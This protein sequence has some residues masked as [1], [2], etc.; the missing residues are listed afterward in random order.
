MA[1]P[2]SP[3][4]EDEK[5]KIADADWLLSDTP[6]AKPKAAPTG[7]SR[8]VADAD[9]SY[10]VLPGHD[11]PSDA[12]EPPPVPVPPVTPRK[13]KPKAEAREPVEAGPPASVDQVWS[14]GAEWGSSLF[15]L[16]FAAVA[17]GV[18]IYIALSA[19]QFMLAFL[20]AGL[21]GAALLAL[22]YPIF[23]TLERPVRITPEQAAK[24]YFAT[25]SHSLP[26]YQRMWLLLSSAGRV[27]PEFSSYGAFKGY[28]K[29]TLAKLQGG[30]ASQLNPLTFQ[31]EDF[32][33]EKSAGMTAINAKYTV[34]VYRGDPE[35]GNEVASYLIATSL[36]KGPDR[37]WYLNNGKLPN[38]QNRG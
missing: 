22:C 32:H 15:S 12:V 36:V 38:E 4:P 35:P 27:S 7:A 23:I 17:F 20:L 30:K 33:S 1:G 16:G 25:L 29:R 14:R 31:V 21:G 5:K 19:G 2:S 6:K 37:M 34:K 10:D 8:T 24:D 11:E 13:P 26:H 9:H 28:W 18:L 3:S